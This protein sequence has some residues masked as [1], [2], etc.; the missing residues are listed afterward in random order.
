[1][2]A[3]GENHVT[4]T[5]NLDNKHSDTARI[6]QKRRPRMTNHGVRNHLTDVTPDHLRRY[7]SSSEMNAPSMSTGMHRVMWQKMQAREAETDRDRFISA[8][9]GHVFKRGG[10][11]GMQGMKLEQQWK[12]LE[13]IRQGRVDTRDTGMAAGR[14]GYTSERQNT[15]DPGIGMPYVLREAMRKASENAHMMNPAVKKH[16][17]ASVGPDDMVTTGP[18]MKTSDYMNDRQMAPAVNRR[19]PWDFVG[20]VQAANQNKRGIRGILNRDPTEAQEQDRLRYEHNERAQKRVR[21]A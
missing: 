16:H 7:T 8:V 2:P 13:N 21:F 10:V 6:Y 12:L 4:A 17:V 3:W 15:R 14:P 19:M 9:G 20:A 11:R 18:T 1:M 5:L